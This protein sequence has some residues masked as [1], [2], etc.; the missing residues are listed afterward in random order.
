[1]P[2]FLTH[3]TKLHLWCTS[4]DEHSKQHTDLLVINLGQTFHGSHIKVITIC[5]AYFSTVL[6]RITCGIMYDGLCI[7]L[8]N[9]YYSPFQL[10]SKPKIQYMMYWYDT[11]FSVSIVSELFWGGDC[12]N[13]LFRVIHPSH[14]RAF[15]DCNVFKVSAY[16][17]TWWHYYTRLTHITYQ[18]HVQGKQSTDLWV[19]N[20]IHINSY[21]M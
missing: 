4:V 16:W 8:R 7:T 2:D 1:M 21:R 18:Q 9:G 14:H 19:Y 5:G 6:V 20:Y 3:S 11:F 10:I 15:H 12:I 17:A 13:C